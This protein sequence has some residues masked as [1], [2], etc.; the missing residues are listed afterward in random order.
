M[1]IPSNDAFIAND[2][3]L[4]HEVFDAAGNF[5]GPITLTVLCSCVLDAGTEDNTEMQAA[6]INQTGNNMGTT[7]I[8]GVISLHPGFIN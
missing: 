2:D 5:T 7:T 6:F 4:A 3:P 1:V 8:G